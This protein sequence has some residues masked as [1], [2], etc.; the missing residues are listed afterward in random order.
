M[1]SCGA[2]ASDGGNSFFEG[3]I[4]WPE[5]SEPGGKTRSQHVFTS[6]REAQCPSDQLPGFEA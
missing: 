1:R 2:F 6:V 5:L 3:S 4:A